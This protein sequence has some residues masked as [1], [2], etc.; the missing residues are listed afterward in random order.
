MSSIRQRLAQKTWSQDWPQEIADDFAVDCELSPPSAPAFSEPLAVA[1][2]EVAALSGRGAPVSLPRAAKMLDRLENWSIQHQSFLTWPP[3]QAAWSRAVRET[4]QNDVYDFL[5][6]AAGYPNAVRQALDNWNGLSRCRV[7][8]WYVD[9][10]DRPRQSAPVAA[11]AE[12]VVPAPP[13]AAASVAPTA[14]VA[15]AP[16]SDR[17]SPSAAARAPS[18]RRTAPPA[19]APAPL[20]T[21]APAPLATPVPVAPPPA[22]AL[23]LLEL[24]RKLSVSSRQG[25]DS[26]LVDGFIKRQV[27]KTKG[28]SDEAQGYWFED[29]LLPAMAHFIPAQ[30]ETLL[31]G[32]PSGLR[33]PLNNPV[34][35]VGQGRFWAILRTAGE[36]TRQALM[37]EALPTLVDTSTWRAVERYQMLSPMFEMARSEGEFVKRLNLWQAWGG[38][39]DAEMPDPETDASAPVGENAFQTQAAPMVSARRWFTKQDNSRWHQALAAYPERSTARSFGP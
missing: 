34:R 20:A 31:A 9:A 22:W 24:T 15:P 27:H 3:T 6:L 30:I 18:A 7:A 33:F 23:E 16:A 21:P 38:D 13:V 26:E 11:V 35:T 10:Y 12:P 14:S 25:P 2:A 28:T 8:S 36:E 39:L 29:E 4:A 19:A 17:T 32:W 1:R 5:A 37:T